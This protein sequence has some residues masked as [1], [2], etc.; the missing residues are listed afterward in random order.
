MNSHQALLNA[1]MNSV[2][3]EVGGGIWH[4]EACD[5]FVTDAMVKDLISIEKGARYA[6]PSGI[7]NVSATAAYEAAVSHGGKSNPWYIPLSSGVKTGSVQTLEYHEPAKQSIPK[8][9]ILPDI[10]VSSNG[11]I[12]DLSANMSSLKDYLTETSTKATA[13]NLASVENGATLQTLQHDGQLIYYYQKGYYD[14]NGQFHRWQS[15]WGKDI[16]SAGC[17]PTSMA[18][19]LANMLHDPS[20]TPTTIANMLNYDDNVGGT[21]VRKA[22]EY[23]GL[24]QTHTIGLDKTKMNN[25]LRNDGK[26]IVAVN[27]GGHYVAV[28]GIDD[29]SNPPRYI[30]NDPNDHDAKLKTWTYYQLAADH[31]MVFH[32]AP[33]G[34]TVDQCIKE[35]T[36]QVL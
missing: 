16:A 25:F 23:Y 35:Q 17:G 5:R 36:Y 13:E 31:T 6:L 30:V 1:G 18:A 28:V 3:Y 7:Q 9:K 21:Y 32:I 15:S 26:M 10:F 8:D 19:C 14:Q 2:Y 12:P 20:I 24:D 34:K 22:A 29:S 11:A 33:K 4:V 27:G